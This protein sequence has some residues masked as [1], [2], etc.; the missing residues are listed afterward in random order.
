MP[1]MPGPSR[2]Q[3]GVRTSVLGWHATNMGTFQSKR[4]YTPDTLPGFTCKR[5]DDCGRRV[6][7][8]PDQQRHANLHLPPE[9]DNIK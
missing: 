7:S 4:R 3:V 5:C 2:T 1:K 6:V 9:Y 8:R